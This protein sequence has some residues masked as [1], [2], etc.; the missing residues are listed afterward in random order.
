M[1][2]QSNRSVI[3]TRH[4]FEAL[5]I[6]E[7]FPFISIQKNIF[8]YGKNFLLV[9]NKD[10]EEIAFSLNEFISNFNI[11]SIINFGICGSL[12]KK[13]EIGDLIQIRKIFLVDSI[14]HKILSSTIS[15][16]RNLPLP[17]ENCLTLTKINEQLPHFLSKYGPLLDMESYYYATSSSLN[18]TSIKLISD[19]NENLEKLTPKKL[20]A[21]LINRGNDICS[22][23]KRL[24]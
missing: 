2:S 17:V 20:K 18:F 24:I 4:R 21:L 13:Y 15:H 19:H 8:N 10:G 23:L 5:P 1:D 12:T 22:I 7:G 16:I 6:L 9:L 3:V 14:N 11:T